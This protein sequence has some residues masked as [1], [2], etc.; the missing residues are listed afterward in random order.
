MRRIHRRD[1]SKVWEFLKLDAA[2]FMAASV[3]A[4]PELL[5]PRELPPEPTLDTSGEIVIPVDSEG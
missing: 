4:E 1:L 3:E 2:I 5:P